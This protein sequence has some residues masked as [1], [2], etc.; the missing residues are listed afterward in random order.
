MLG[1]P[2]RLCSDSEAGD[3]LMSLSAPRLRHLWKKKVLR[4]VTAQTT[5]QSHV[6][7]LCLDGVSE[8]ED[9]GTP[10]RIKRCRGDGAIDGMEESLLAMT[11]HPNVS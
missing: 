5:A 10:E 7:L 1:P 6:C 9:V 3:V 8:Q 11:G 2:G 4:G